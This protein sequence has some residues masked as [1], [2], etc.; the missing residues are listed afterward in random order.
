MLILLSVQLTLGS[1]QF[2]AKLSQR[3]FILDNDMTILFAN[4]MAERSSN[5]SK[6][7][8]LYRP[9]LEAVPLKEDSRFLKCI[10]ERAAQ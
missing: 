7:D 6:A 1:R 3:V 10:K 2:G 8:Y 5:F 4:E 9:F